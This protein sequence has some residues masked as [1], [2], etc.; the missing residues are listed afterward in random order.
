MPLILPLL[1]AIPAVLIA[2]ELG[3][4]LI[5]RRHARRYRFDSAGVIV[6]AAGLDLP[7]SRSTGVLLL[8]GFGDTPQ[9]LARISRALAD[10][11]YAVRVPLLPGHGRTI[12]DFARSDG[13]AWLDEARR[14]FDDMVRR[15]D[16]VAVVGLSM[17]AALAAI[18][19]GE[20]PP[21][22][23]A[24]IALAPYIVVGPRVRRLARHRGWIHAF[25]PWL[26]AADERSIRDDDARATSLGYGMVSARLLHELATVADRAREALPRIVAPTL[27]IMSRDDN[28]VDARDV[29]RALADLRAPDTRIVW[30]EASGHVITVDHERDRV[31]EETVAWLDRHTGEAPAV[32]AVETSDGGSR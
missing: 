17:G 29:E 10:R 15:H 3:R 1:A 31:V 5:E 19:A 11:G 32:A 13:A 16:R 7:G 6:G 28:R 30:L 12:A 2:R 27:V 23:A 18:L 9:A 4:R 21:R 24:L 20:R 26:P 25:A 22:L 14:A 8:H